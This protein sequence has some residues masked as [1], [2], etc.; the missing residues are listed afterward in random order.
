MLEYDPDK[1]ASINDIAKSKFI[2]NQTVSIK[3]IVKWEFVQ[4]LLSQREDELFSKLL[5][6]ILETY[7]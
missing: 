5:G 7:D 3:R 4:E 1:R 2:F 6:V